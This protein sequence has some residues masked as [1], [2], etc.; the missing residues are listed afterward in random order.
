MKTKVLLSVHPAFT[1][2]RFAS[3]G[4]IHV[5][6]LRRY[7]CTSERPERT[8]FGSA[9]FQFIT[10]GERSVACGYQSSN[11]QIFQS[12]NLPIRASE[13]NLCLVHV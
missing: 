6:L 13:R 5:Y 12:S 11:L 7:F 2:N 1:P 8:D 4:V 10:A 9:D 3:L